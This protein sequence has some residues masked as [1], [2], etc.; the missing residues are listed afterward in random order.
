M[1][2]PCLALLLLLVVVAGCPLSGTAEGEGEGGEGEGV[3]GEGE[4]GEGEEGEGEEG[5]G[6]EGEGEAGEGEEGEGEEGEGEPEPTAPIVAGAGLTFIETSRISG[7]AAYREGTTLMVLPRTSSTATV[8]ATAVE[9]AVFSGDQLVAFHGVVGNVAATAEVRRG[10]AATVALG[11]N[12]K[13]STVDA[14]DDG[15]HL[16]WEEVADAAAGTE[17]LMLDGTAV[18][19]GTRKAKTR[20]TA[21]NGHLVVGANLPTAAGTEKTIR[22]FPLGGGAGAVLAV[23]NTSN[24]TAVTRSG[25]SVLYGDN[26]NGNVVNITLKP[27]NDGA[28]VVLAEGADDAA[29]KVTPNDNELIYLLD[30]DTSG[31]IEAVQLNGS[32]RRRVR[33]PSGALA[34]DLVSVSWDHVVYATARSGGLRSLGII[35]LLGAN[36]TDL[37]VNADGKGFTADGRFYVF[38]DNVTAGV[39]RLQAYDTTTNTIVS[40]AADVA[41]VTDADANHLVFL[42]TDAVLSVVALSTAAIEVIDTG[43]TGFGLVRDAPNGTSSRV[44]YGKADGIWRKRF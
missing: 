24:E 23:D 14:S 29:F 21:D 13:I 5:E 9:H 30:T 25:A 28:A 7:D 11:T 31:A 38:V 15:Q 44:A 8:V 36:D 41:K 12:I 1:L 2:R 33:A 22:T 43:V 39:G 35:G 3:E 19:S 17:N 4:E 10:D 26:E 20:F 16:F 40:L 34:I 32:G 42:G 6:E 27:A 18:L 37:G